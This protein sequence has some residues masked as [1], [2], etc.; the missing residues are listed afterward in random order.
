MARA[1]QGD[2]TAYRHL[3]TQVMKSLEGYYRRRV[4][5]AENAAD[6]LQLALLKLHL[7]R[8]TYDPSR[9]FE[10]WLFAIARSVLID[11]FRARGRRVAAELISDEV[12]DEA[13]EDGGAYGR[14]AFR[15]AL[16]QLTAEQQEAL[17]LMKIDGLSV[18]AAAKRV[19]VSQGNMKVRIH[20]ALKALKRSLF[21]DGS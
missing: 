17:R 18:E 15:E 7:A 5:E 3:L 8:H 20:R 21:A 2:Q 16:E 9:P 14:L 11:Y 6:V 13:A 10:P 1:Q 19:G 4:R 12:F